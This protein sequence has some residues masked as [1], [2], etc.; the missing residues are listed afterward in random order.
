MDK[1][2]ISTLNDLIETCKDGE[3]G[4]KS[5]AEDVGNSQLKKTLLTYAA[6]CSASARELSALVTAHGGNPE[7]K[8]S[9][10]GTLHRRWIDIKSL[11]MG[12]DDEAVLNECERGEDVAK[13]SYRRALE[14]DLP[15]DVK[16]VIERQYQ[17]VLQNHDAIK[18]LR[19]RAHAA[20]L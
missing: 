7:T 8:S 16:A 1:D 19:D 12:K 4:F 3:E 10:S 9:L 5:C 17:G 11:V 2:V 20:A 6:S 18:I 15:L 14:K 13:K